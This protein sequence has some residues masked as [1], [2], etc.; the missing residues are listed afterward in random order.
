MVYKSENI[1]QLKQTLVHVVLQVV[2][3]V[4]VWLVAQYDKVYRLK[5]MSLA[6][7]VKWHLK[8]IFINE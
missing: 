2:V 7:E 1:R 6:Q 3:H 8:K 4:V 5:M